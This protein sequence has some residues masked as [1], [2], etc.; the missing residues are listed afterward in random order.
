MSDAYVSEGDS[1]GMNNV[2]KC[3]AS[4]LIAY[5]V[6]AL[7]GVNRWAYIWLKGWYP[8]WEGMSWTLLAIMLTSLSRFVYGSR[9]RWLGF[10]AASGYAAGIVVYQ[11]EPLLRDGTFRN[12]VAT[13]RVDGFL[14][15]IGVAALFPILTLSWLTGLAAAAAFAA[16]ARQGA[17]DRRLAAYLLG[18]MVVMGWAFFLS[19]DGIPMKW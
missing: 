4:I 17:T 19:H 11:V 18:A 1:G 12:T 16:I 2:A 9:L 6:C 15:Y 14:T 13:I 7:A 10:G 3:L 5:G 8:I